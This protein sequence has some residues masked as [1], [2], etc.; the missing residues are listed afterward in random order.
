MSADGRDADGRGGCCGGGGGGGGSVAD[1]DLLPFGAAYDTRAQAT[2]AVK[3][4]EMARSGKGFRVDSSRSSGAHV[5]FRCS[6]VIE[7][8]TDDNGKP[9]GKTVWKGEN[10]PDFVEPERFAR[11]TD[12]AFAKRRREDLEYN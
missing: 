9:C 5:E 7:T 2:A 8:V 10:L 11:E 3:S 1:D 4:A 6:S 12:T